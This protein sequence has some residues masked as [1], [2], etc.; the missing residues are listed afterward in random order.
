[1]FTNQHCTHNANHTGATP[2]TACAAPTVATTAAGTDAALGKSDNGGNFTE[3]AFDYTATILNSPSNPAESIAVI[4][5]K[6]SDGN[7]WSDVT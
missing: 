4:L 3:P 1:M 2:A 7:T 5:Q 6:S